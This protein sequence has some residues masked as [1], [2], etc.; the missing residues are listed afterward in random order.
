MA[1][2]R[3]AV[4]LASTL[5]LC[6]VGCPLLAEDDFV[7]VAPVA[8]PAAGQGGSAGTAGASAGDTAS[9]GSAIEPRGGTGGADEP[10]PACTPCADGER[11]RA[12]ADCMSGRCSSA[13]TCRACGLRLTSVQTVC[14]ASCTRC[15][16]GTCFIECEGEAACKESVLVCPP[17]MAC[18]V[19]CSGEGACE[20]ASVACP[21]EFPCDVSC[22]AKQSCKGLTA[23][24]ASGPCGLSCAAD[25]AC[26]E[27]TLRCGDDRCE[28]K[29]SAGAETPQTTC[30]ESCDCAACPQ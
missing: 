20:K 1:G 22:T 6:T 15:S 19:A 13:G 14:P 4:L 9:G 3:T 21:A 18:H 30:G 23:A 27:T 5:A 7:V 12:D 8:S 2:A 11:C 25:A 29:C 28:A 26:K 24:C 16:A 10:P 17:N